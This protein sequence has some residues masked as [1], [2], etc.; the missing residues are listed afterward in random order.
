MQKCKC[1]L[2]AY[3]LLGYAEFH[4]TFE[5]IDGNDN[6]QDDMDDE[7]DDDNNDRDVGNDNNDCG[8]NDEQRL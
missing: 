1:C 8:S 3:H 7:D 4:D 6:A 2:V 5:C